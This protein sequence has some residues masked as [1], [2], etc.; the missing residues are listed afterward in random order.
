MKIWVDAD[1]SVNPQLK[2]GL[3][4]FPIFWGSKRS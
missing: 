1:A 2:I 4:S 3:T